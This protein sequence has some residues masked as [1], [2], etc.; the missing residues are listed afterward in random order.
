MFTRL[1]FS[2]LQIEYGTLQTKGNALLMKDVIAQGHVP[3]ASG[4]VT[5]TF[6]S[7]ETESIDAV[8][9]MLDW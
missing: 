1:Y 7:Q 3:S 6:T 2:G 9:F 8:G 4:K 5:L